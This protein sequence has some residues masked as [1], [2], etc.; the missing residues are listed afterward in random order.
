VLENQRNLRE[1]VLNMPSDSN[2]PRRSRRD[3]ESENAELWKKL[4]DVYNTLDDL[5][6]EDEE[7]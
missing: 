6:D 5:F 4:E 2:N 1:E 7:D 3:L